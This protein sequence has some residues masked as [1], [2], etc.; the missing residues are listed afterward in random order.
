MLLFRPVLS[1]FEDIFD[2]VRI[3]STV[4][5][6][7]PWGVRRELRA[8]LDLLPALVFDLTT[9][10]STVCAATDA[11]DWGGG[12]VYTALSA[13]E[14]AWM[15][16][17][18]VSKGWNDRVDVPVEDLPAREDLRCPSQLADFV[19]TSEWKC[20]I[21][22]KW[23]WPDH[24]TLQEGRAHLLQVEWLARQAPRHRCR[25]PF[26]IDNQALVGALAKGRSSSRR[27]NRICRKTAA[28]Y[29]YSSI[30]PLVI[31]VPTH[32]QPADGPSRPH[33]GGH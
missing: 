16:S 22:H 18:A 17:H 11:S 30:R 31:W 7:M 10:Y 23:R 19:R 12:A 27:L 15:H 33:D 28:L 21:R 32:L 24:I 14:A 4:K 5:R 25:Q 8:A 2:F 13:D 26:L 20:S 1:V 3:V 29:I 9:P 6:V